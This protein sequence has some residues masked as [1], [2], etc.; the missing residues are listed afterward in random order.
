MKPR[1]LARDSLGRALRFYDTVSVRCE[2][3]VNFMS[4]KNKTSD[5]RGKYCSKK[6][7][8]KYRILPTNNHHHTWKGDDVSY[9]ALH[10]WVRRKLGK[11]SLCDE[12]KTRDS[13]QFEWANISGEYKRNLSDWKRLCSK[14]HRNFDNIALKGWVTRKAVKND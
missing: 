2:C 3:G 10:A 12:C 9:S 11:P 8:Y 4:S 1:I 5:G 14:C 13:K 7:M 6:C